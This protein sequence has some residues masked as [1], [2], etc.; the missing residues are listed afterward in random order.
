M[1]S[2]DQVQASRPLPTLRLGSKGDDV[3]YLQEALNEYGYKVTVDGIFGKKT[4]AAVKKFQKSRGLTPDG[5][6]GPQTW[7]ALRFD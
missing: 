2:V 6:V 3:N 1:Q 5:I 7:S 4:E